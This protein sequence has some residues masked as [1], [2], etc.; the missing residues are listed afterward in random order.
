MT[1]PVHSVRLLHPADLPACMALK[2][3]AGWNQTE[4]DWLKL[5]EFAPDGC[6]G[7]E[8]DGVVRATTTA[9]CYGVELAWIGMV[10]TDERFRRHGLAAS[11]MQHVIAY[12]TQRPVDWIK[13]DAT[14]M[15]QP[16]YRGLGFED[17]CAVERWL[18]PGTPARSF[19][20]ESRELNGGFARGRPG[21]NAAYFGPCK[22]ESPATAR[23]LVEW[24][25]HL[26]PGEA[27][28]WD[29]LPDNTEAVD[30]ARAHGFAPLR[31]L[32]RMGRRGRPDAPPRPT[33]IPRTYAIAGFEWG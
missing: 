22:A 5:F 28:Y 25:L 1:N 27:I 19:V 10:L 29:I 3:E 13:L 21:S 33:D 12:L 2:E 23:D 11:L 31:K 24:F 14:G 18:R 16:L 9:V 7:I 6:F 26:H 8:I 17:E 30:L 15:G 20:E 4:E 32:V